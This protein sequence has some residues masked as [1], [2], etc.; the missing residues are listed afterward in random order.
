MSTWYWANAWLIT[1]RQLTPPTEVSVVRHTDKTVWLRPKS[2]KEPVKAIRHS[3]RGSY[4]PSE[5]EA[6]EY[7]DRKLRSAILKAAA[8]VHYAE[9]ELELMKQYAQK[10]CKTFPLTNPEEYLT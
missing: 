9:E 8:E 3:S 5:K 6:W 7:L 2:G 10:Q 1:I 4:F